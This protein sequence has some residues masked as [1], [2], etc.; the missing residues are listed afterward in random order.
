MGQIRR[1][2]STVRKKH[3]VATRCSW[4]NYVSSPPNVVRGEVETD[5]FVVIYHVL[6]Q[7]HKVLS[8]AVEMTGVFIIR[9]CSNVKLIRTRFSFL[10]EYRLNTGK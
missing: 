3:D 2:G 5:E 8:I 7:K 9:E 6:F 1:I 10:A 4:V